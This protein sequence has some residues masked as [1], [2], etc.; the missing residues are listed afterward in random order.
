MDRRSSIF[1]H[2]GGVLDVHSRL[3]WIV[4]FILT[5]VVM[6]LACHGQD[7]PES[8]TSRL[9]KKSNKKDSLKILIAAVDHFSD[10]DITVADSISHAAS[11]LAAETGDSVIIYIARSRSAILLRNQLRYDSSLVLLEECLD[12]WRRRDDHKKYHD[13]ARLAGITYMRS[14]DLLNA[15]KYIHQIC[16]YYEDIKLPYRLGTSLRLLGT[17]YRQEGDTDIALKHYLRSLNLLKDHRDLTAAAITHQSLGELYA[18]TEDEKSALYHYDEALRIAQELDKPFRQVS[19]LM[20]IS[21]V[22][23]DP[24]RKEMIM[25]DAYHLLTELDVPRILA[26]HCYELGSF[27]AE[28]G[29]IEKSQ[30]YLEESATACELVTGESSLQHNLVLAAITASTGG[31]MDPLFTAQMDKSMQG[32]RNIVKNRNAHLRLAGIYE[33]LNNPEQVYFH[34]REA[35]I[36]KDSIV[37]NEKNQVIA[38]LQTTYK[39]VERNQ[40]LKQLDLQA[41]IAKT[42]LYRQQIA[43]VLLVAVLALISVFLYRLFSQKRVIQQQ[44]NT[45]ALLLREIHHR[46]KNNLQ[47]IS[48]LLRLQSHQTTDPLAIDALAEGQSRVQAMSLIHQHLYQHEDLKHLDL[49]SYMEQ[50]VNS[51]RVT[52]LGE[53]KLIRI[54]TEV[55]EIRIDIDH[56]VPLGLTVNELLQEAL[57]HVVSNGPEKVMSVSLKRKDEQIELTIT[58]DAPV[59]IACM[60]KEKTLSSALVQSFTDKLSAKMARKTEN[61]LAK[62]VI[63]IPQTTLTG[64][65]ST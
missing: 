10:R 55:D 53:G 43:L 62:V 25:L 41:S 5:L 26:R 13:V 58:T 37:T 52:A 3:I 59:D 35:A 19:A 64:A 45:K 24:T 14:G 20:G 56:L 29:N 40:L 34:R 42:R 11:R 44:N 27:Y 46:V 30:K 65:P 12:F 22:V 9:A 18:Y 2:L 17:V 28:R 51:V 50:L 21:Q 15:K 57:K 49:P 1:F 31:E 38:E 47:V 23:D 6:P 4:L 39:T 16:D 7:W 63:D 54:D 8:I 61:G 48:S 32:S 33:R 60:D 36:Y